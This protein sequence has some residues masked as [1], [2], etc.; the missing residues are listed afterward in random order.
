MHTLKQWQNT[1][2]TKNELNIT[3]GIQIPQSLIILGNVV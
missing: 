3:H 2:Q 1:S